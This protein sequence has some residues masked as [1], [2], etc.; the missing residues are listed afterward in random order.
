MRLAAAAG[1]W[2]FAGTKNPCHNA[3]ASLI[4]FNMARWLMDAKSFSLNGHLPCSQDLAPMN[5]FLF[6]DIKKQLAGKP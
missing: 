4:F 6:S 1:E 2:F 5:F 3:A